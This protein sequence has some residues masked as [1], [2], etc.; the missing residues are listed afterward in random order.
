[1]CTMQDMQWSQRYA[2]HNRRYMMELLVDCIEDV[3][4]KTPDMDQIINR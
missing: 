4:H 1:M 2:H 3:V